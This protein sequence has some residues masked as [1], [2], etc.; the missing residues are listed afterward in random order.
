[1]ILDMQGGWKTEERGG[2]E[3]KVSVA[4]GSL[5]MKYHFLLFKKDNFHGFL[6]ERT[7]TDFL[8]N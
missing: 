3:V 8:A 6:G 5:N 2:V 4:N 1:M 7:S